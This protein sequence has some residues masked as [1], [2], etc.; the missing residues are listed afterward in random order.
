MIKIN[1]ELISGLLLK[2]S[3]AER[4]RTNYNFH[5]TPG[6]TL[7]RML[8]ILN[9]GTYIRPHKHENPDKREAFIILRGKV[10]V[11]TFHDDGSILDHFVL[12]QTQ[13]HF[14]CEIA[15][16]TW[17][18]I[19]CIEDNSVLYELKDGPYQPEND[20]VFAA[21]SPMEGSEYAGEF[22][23]ELLKSLHL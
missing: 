11:V 14:A 20:K 18:T 21:W 7:Q 1:N 3:Q 19:I 17:H 13:A 22:I 9:T 5:K 8:N 2:A 12:D 23:Q 16:K 4:R 15:P 10:L 6:D